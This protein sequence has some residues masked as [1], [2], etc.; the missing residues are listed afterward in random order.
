MNVRKTSNYQNCPFAGLSLTSFKVTDF[1]SDFVCHF[2]S[3]KFRKD[4]REKN[5]NHHQQKWVWQL[6]LDIG[7]RILTRDQRLGD[8]SKILGMFRW[9][10]S[11]R[12]WWR[13]SSLNMASKNT[14][15]PYNPHKSTCRRSLSDVWAL[16]CTRWSH[17]CEPRALRL[18]E[19]HRCTL[20]VTDRVC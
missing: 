15:N 4:S 10:V 18:T 9:L 8:G 14:V 2:P 7:N 19:R 6:V 20:C 16:Y 11:M 13:Y 12:P 3:S 17:A 5:S 1:K